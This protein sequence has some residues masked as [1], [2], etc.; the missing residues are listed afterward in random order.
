MVNQLSVRNTYE[1]RTKFRAFR[2]EIVPF[3]VIS[4]TCESAAAMVYSTYKKQRILYLHFRGFKPPTIV[5]LLLEEK[6]KASRWGVAKFLKRFREDGTI[7]RRV[8]TGRPSKVTAEV[9]AIVEEQMRLDDE[10]TAFQLHRL[11]TEKG[12][13]LTRRTILRCRTQL[14]W[15][16]RGSSY[17]QLI[18]VANKEKRLAWALRNR[19]GTFEDVVWS[20]E[21][22]IQLETHRRFCCRKKGEWPRNKPRFVIVICTYAAKLH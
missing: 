20:D 3:C 14:G 15:T 16:F 17:C 22:S 18:R 7:L 12:Y 9:K 13:N 4:N 6:M 2:F 5:K 21:S 11:L 19:N 10:T 8:G 1:N